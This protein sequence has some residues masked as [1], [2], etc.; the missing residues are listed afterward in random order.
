MIRG[1][2]RRTVLLMSAE[3]KILAWFAQELKQAFSELPGDLRLRIDVDPQ[4]LM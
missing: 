1:R 2:L 4:S 3:R